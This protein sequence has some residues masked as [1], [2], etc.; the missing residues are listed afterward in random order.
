MREGDG[1]GGRTREAERLLFVELS[2]LSEWRG[3]VSFDSIRLGPIRD[4]VRSTCL[5][6]TNTCSRFLSV[7]SIPSHLILILYTLSSLVFMN[8]IVTTATTTASTTTTNSTTTIT[9]TPTSPLQHATSKS[10]R[11]WQTHLETLFHRSKDRF[12]DVVWSLLTE[13]DGE[14]TGEEVYGHKGWS[15][16][17]IS[18][19]HPPI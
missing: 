19:T 10:T 15:F 2:E 4:S 5:S 3:W 6:H 17:L 12:P 8:A 14:P 18:S 13:E 16:T 9:S 7:S 11:V 1:N